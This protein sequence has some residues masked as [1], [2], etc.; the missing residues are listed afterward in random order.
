MICVQY[1]PEFW[2]WLMRWDPETRAALIGAGAT[3]LSVIAAVVGVLLK[4]AWDRKKHTQ[5]HLLNLRRDGGK[6]RDI[7][8]NLE[9]VIEGSN[10]AKAANENDKL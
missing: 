10:I 8:K 9:R 1:S 6:L 5:E 3:V 2:N 7:A 4:L